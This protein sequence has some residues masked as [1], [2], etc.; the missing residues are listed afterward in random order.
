MCKI[1]IPKP[2]ID[3]KIIL[4]LLLILSVLHLQADTTDSF[5]SVETFEWIMYAYILAERNSVERKKD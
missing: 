2:E 3:C 4:Q 1:L 5:L